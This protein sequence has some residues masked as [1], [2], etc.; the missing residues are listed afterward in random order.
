MSKF[1]KVTGALLL[2]LIIVGT[3]G[4]LNRWHLAY[5]PIAA[6]MI[7]PGSDV[8]FEELAPMDY[9]DEA[10]WAALPWLEREPSDGGPTDAYDA[11]TGAADVFY[12]H[13][14][15]YMSSAAWNIPPAEFRDTRL[16]EAVMLPDQPRA[17]NACC[18]VFAPYYRQATFYAFLTVRPDG[19]EAIDA[20]YEDVRSAF[21]HFIDNWSDGRPF[22]IAGHSQGSLHAQRLIA[23]EI[24]GT[25][26][27]S[28]L[29]VA[30]V[31]GYVVP[32]TP[33]TFVCSEP[34]QNAC[35]LTWNNVRQS[36]W[37]PDVIHKLPLWDD[38]GTTRDVEGEF[39]CA[40]PA[41]DGAPEVDEGYTVYHVPDNN[42]W[43]NGISGRCEGAFFV[44]DEPVDP[45]FA[46]FPMS[47]GWLHVYEFSHMWI[48]IGEDAARRIEAH[49][50]H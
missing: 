35:I 19:Y 15:S 43:P 5:G 7:A 13:P 44:L 37:L 27:E 12:I 16:L 21:L 25:P 45:D 30:Y 1:L 47:R 42:L 2:V 23:E 46:A 18:R 49:Q 9:G 20:A 3:L 34:N 6:L 39:F 38:G 28:Q 31:P 32:T 4:W 41:P 8:T 11:S 36:H 22:I 40:P 50:S 17:L 24:M 29:V 10:M 14:T 48:A 26:L 33:S